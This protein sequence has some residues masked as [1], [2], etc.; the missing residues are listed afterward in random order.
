MRRLVTALVALCLAAPATGQLRTAALGQGARSWESG[1]GDGEPVILQK[2]ARTRLD[3]G[4]APAHD[5]ELAHF[6][7]WIAPRFFDG[8][9]NVA[10]LVL[11][12]S[13]GIRAP[14]SLNIVPTVLRAQLRGVINGDHEVAYVRRPSTFQPDMPAFGIWI[15]LDF[16]RVVGVE[17]IRFYP[18]NTAVATPKL[19]FE[20]DYL[21]AYELWVN[22]QLTDVVGGAPDALVQRVMANDAPI[23]DVKVPPQYARLIKLRSLTEVPFEIDEIEVYGSGYLRHADYYTDLIDLGDRATI[24]PIRW[25]ERAVGEEAFSRLD[26]RVRT[27]DDDTPI[28]LSRRVTAEVE[29]DGVV[30]LVRSTEEVTPEEYWSLES[31]LRLPLADDT[32]R[33]SAWKPVR[34]GESIT[35]RNP[36][37]YV[38]FHLHFEGRLA[39]ARHVDRLYFQYL[40]PPMADTLRGEVFPRLASA[41]EPASFRYAV[42]VRGGGDMLGFDEL[43]VD[44]NVEVAGIRSLTVNGQA[45]PFDILQRR[46]D[47]FRLSFPL[48]RQDEAVLEFT[49]DLPIFRFG[50]TFSSRAYNSRFPTV[51]QEVEPGQAIDFGPGDFVELS[52]LTVA[53]PTPQIGKLVGQIALTSEVITPNGD[54]V[55]DRLGAYFNLL[56]LT[57]TA[58]VVLE[59]RDLAGR[60]VA[61]VENPSVSIGPA[62]LHWD[63]TDDAGRVV[64]PGCYI[65]VLRVMADAFEERH[66]GTVAVAY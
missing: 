17:R 25:V 41:E 4:N 29:V 58:P 38:Q 7:G 54:G 65:W 60:R 57:G 52:G 12:G 1:G 36:R 45:A 13:G 35:V 31:T 3:T 48:M 50:T 53:I 32:E 14:N 44:S 62:E 9:E 15:N 21:R 64:P 16:G 20:G 18:R 22:D 8:T 51:P 10:S 40:N 33:W 47:G 23:V 19:P 37:R 27:G 55:N 46:E 5:V 63:G 66:L 42:L 34:S 28:F 6:P 56:Q 30:E 24:G 39:D 59:I 11:E 49:F 61:S 26:V 43:E 2:V